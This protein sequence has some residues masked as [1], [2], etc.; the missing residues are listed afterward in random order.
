MNQ[1]FEEYQD[2][3]VERRGNVFILTL[4]RAPENRLT[5]PWCREIIRAYND[6]RRALGTESDGAVIMKGNDAKFFCTVCTFRYGLHR[7]IRSDLHL[8]YITHRS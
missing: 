2:L 5:A 1:Q 7:C 8:L 6:I 3:R 4:Q